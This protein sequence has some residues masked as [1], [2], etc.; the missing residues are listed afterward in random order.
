MKVAA[1]DCGTNSFLCLI[2]EVSNLEIKKIYSD[3]IRIVKLGENLTQTKRLSP[4][5]LSRAR[6]ALTEFKA[7]IDKQSPEK[8][9][10]V[11][12][13]AARDAENSE[14][15]IQIMSDLQIPIRIVSGA[16]EA[17]LTFLGVQSPNRSLASTAVVDIGGGSTEFVYINANS[18]QKEV[19]VDMGC[20]RG[21]ELFLKGEVIS[22]AQQIEFENE[23]LKQFSSLEA[24]KDG[25]LKAK[26]IVAVSGTPTSIATMQI[27]T[28]FSRDQVEGFEITEDI[29]NSWQAR[30]SQMN[31]LEKRKIKGLDPKRADVIL[32]GV[33]ILKCAMKILDKSKLTV[34]TRGLRYGIAKVLSDPNQ[35]KIILND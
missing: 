24:V 34:S 20:V 2:A 18:E 13:S 7:E 23:V 33:I 30:L 19:S 31:S 26:E 21:T 11:A 29:L 35:R 32:A 25:S 5:A 22:E 28:E 10:A 16:T 8:I 3:E 14:S 4:A 1:I 27:G 15:F 9:L 12:T 6:E 17:Q